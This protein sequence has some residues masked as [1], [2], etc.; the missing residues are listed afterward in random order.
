[1]LYAIFALVTASAAPLV[2][3][4][5][6]LFPG[7]QVLPTDVALVESPDDM[8]GFRDLDAVVGQEL[9]GRVL[10]GEIVRPERLFDTGASEI[11]RQLRDGDRIIPLARPAGRVLA[12]G[13][14]VDVAREGGTVVHDARVIDVDAEHV[15][16]AA[17]LGDVLALLGP[18]ELRF[19]VLPPVS[20]GIVHLA[21]AAPSPVVAAAPVVP[22]A[23]VA[24]A[25]WVP[26]V[27]Y[28]NDVFAGKIMYQSD[29]VIRQ[30]PAELVLDGRSLVQIAD[31][32]G[33][34]AAEPLYAGEVARIERTVVP[35]QPTD[36]R[37]LLGQESVAVLMPYVRGSPGVSV[38]ARVD[39]L[40]TGSPPCVVVA[41][42]KV[43]VIVRGQETLMFEPDAQA[44]NVGI[45]MM[46]SEM[47]ALVAH[48]APVVIAY[49][50]ITDWRPVDAYT[51]PAP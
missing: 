46:A 50:A 21:A 33:R 34:V 1:M 27:T 31:A 30:V 36:A 47:D 22:P 51:C 10:Q 25:G 43:G 7:L 19:T 3:A 13:D 26:V 9:I 16:V 28:A 49:R 40:S 44:E 45:G 48:R 15:W 11:D 18:G 17:P 32:I 12:K 20:R 8:V 39:L 29:F 42:A 41:A 38:G 2:V 14:R 35:W 5:R 6:E 24:K 4:T 23:P 37:R